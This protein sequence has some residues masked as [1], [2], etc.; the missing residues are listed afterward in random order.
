MDQDKKSTEAD[1]QITR[2]LRLKQ[3]KELAIKKTSE[4]AFLPEIQNNTN[5]KKENRITIVKIEKRVFDKIRKV[6]KD[7]NKLGKNNSF[8]INSA[9]LINMILKQVIE[10]NLDYNTAIDKNTLENILS[11]IVKEQ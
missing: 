1:I 3:E 9:K 4:N 8:H 2:L 10:L 7:I 6:V 11:K 5:L